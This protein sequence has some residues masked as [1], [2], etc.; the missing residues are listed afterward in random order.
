MRRLN[1]GFQYGNNSAL[2]GV[3]FPALRVCSVYD[4][5]DINQVE[6]FGSV[7]K[8]TS[9]DDAP[10][11]VKVQMQ[12]NK[13]HCSLLKKCPLA[14]IAAGLVTLAIILAVAGSLIIVRYRRRKQKVGSTC[15]S[16]SRL[17][18]V[19]VKELSNRSA[20]HVSSFGYL[21]GS[22][23][24]DTQ[25]G[26]GFLTEK[27]PSYCIRLEEI[28]SA[29]QYF[30]EAKLLGRSN[31]SSV[32]KGTLWDSSFV[33]VKCIKLTCCRSEEGE[34]LKG[35]ELLTSL[36]HENLV[37]FR[38]FCCSRGRGEC[39]LV[40]DFAPKGTLSQY[41]DVESGSRYFLDWSIRVSVIN[42][43]ARGQFQNVLSHIF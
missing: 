41:L 10:P 43:I 12:C 29:T 38:G 2:C 32:Y 14:A 34:F 22:L 16:D 4:H 39:F 31:S 9:P 21:E 24:A 25:N 1:R 33:A 28:E 7:T 37:R 13:N 35:L 30:S 5:Q 27:Y 15:S 20:S 3:G 11:S 6:P 23:I 19:Q 8:N 26:I 36:K 18:S 40:H 42:G 17:S